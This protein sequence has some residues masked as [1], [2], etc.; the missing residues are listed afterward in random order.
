MKA[1]NEV[2]MRDPFVLT[3]PDGRYYLFGTTDENLWRGPGTGFD[4]YVGKDLE[5]WE[6]PFPAFR[7]EA[8]FWGTDNFWAPEVHEW[9]GGFYM[10][11][12]FKAEGRCRATQILYSDRP[13]GPFRVHSPEP[14]TPAGWE[15]LDGTFFA[16][17]EGH[18]WL[19]FCHEWVQVRD[20]EICAIRL[21]DDLRGTIGES[22][23]LFRASEAAWTR[24]IRRKDGSLDPAMRVTD[25]PFLHRLS[26]GGLLL[27]WSSF[28]DTGYAMGSAHS[29]S[30]NIL[31]PW[32]QNPLPI[33]DR[34]AGHGM[35]FRGNDGELYLTHHTPNHTPDERFH[36]VRVRETATDIVC[37]GDEA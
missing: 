23:L 25:G 15:C 10:F 6:G 4:V 2:R 12:S 36:Y 13:E 37:V 27:I 34:D 17:D 3:A 22:T 28:S 20:G 9:R 8:V 7:P 33:I 18:P 19:V 24:A 14:V 11:A 31:G 29:A 26:N 16:D 21:T 35:C 1:S 32:A 30:G 5:S